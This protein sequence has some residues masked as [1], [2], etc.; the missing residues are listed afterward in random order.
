MQTQLL[1]EA[2]PFRFDER[3]LAAAEAVREYGYGHPCLVAIRNERGQIYR[4]FMPSDPAAFM[5]LCEALDD[6]G[7]S[8][9]LED[10]EGTR[11]GYAAIFRTPERREAGRSRLGN[12]VRRVLKGVP[13]RRG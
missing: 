9:E 3:I 8:D 13:E 7:L 11:D 12:R 10:E 1:P 6:L 2:E 5:A 4:Q